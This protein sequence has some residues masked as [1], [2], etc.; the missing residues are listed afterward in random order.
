MSISNLSGSK[1]LQRVELRFWLYFKAHLDRYLL[2]KFEEKI[3]SNNEVVSNKFV[4]INFS[5]YKM[6][7]NNLSFS[8]KLH[9]Y[10][11]FASKSINRD[12]CCKNFNEKYLVTRKISTNIYFERAITKFYEITV[13]NPFGFT[14]FQ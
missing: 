7:S 10:V 2:C 14:C 3:F 12:T 8:N 1:L 5:S 6:T 13:S 4:E 9:Q 11:G